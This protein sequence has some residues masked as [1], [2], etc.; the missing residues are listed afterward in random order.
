MYISVQKGRLQKDGK[1][2]DCFGSLLQNA[3]SA[4]YPDNVI[5]V[6]LVY[7]AFAQFKMSINMYFVHI[8]NIW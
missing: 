6:K 3:F 5:I 4:Y 2:R 8:T 1:R 7:L